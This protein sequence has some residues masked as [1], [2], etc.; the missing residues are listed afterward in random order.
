MDY[1]VCEAMEASLY[2]WDLDIR[3]REISLENESLEKLLYLHKYLWIIL[4]V[5]MSL[6]LVRPTHIH[7]KIQSI[8]TERE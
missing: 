2:L 3:G 8:V 5:R 7:R 1:F 6:T 4:V